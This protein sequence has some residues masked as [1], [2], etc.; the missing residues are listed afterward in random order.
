MLRYTAYVTAR[1]HSA[2]PTS[3][4]ASWRAAGL[5]LLCLC[6]VAVQALATAHTHAE[7]P[8]FSAAEFAAHIHLHDH[9]HAP[10]P[11]HPDPSHPAPD[12]PAPDCRICAVATSEDDWVFGTTPDFDPA[13]ASGAVAGLPSATAPQPLIRLACAVPGR[14]SSPLHRQETSTDLARAP[15]RRA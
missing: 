5:A 2:M 6:L 10:A 7:R 4:F 15:P 9:S 3:R 11:D 13:A 1:P 8:D 14:A 12:R